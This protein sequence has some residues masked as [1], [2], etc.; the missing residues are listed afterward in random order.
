MRNR[1]SERGG[2]VLLLVLA[3][4][5]WAAAGAFGAHRLVL[6]GW[7]LEGD[8]LLGDRAALAADSALAWALAGAGP[9][10]AGGDEAPGGPSET[11]LAVPAWVLGPEPGLGL[12]GEVRI[13]RL[14]P[15]PA[16]GLW[17]R[18]TVE[19]RV[20]VPATRPVRTFRQI[21]EAYGCTPPGGTPAVRAW[22][23]VR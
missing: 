4:L 3:A 8:A 19:G 5:A 17:W 11:V 15:G 10:L 9:A 16:P 12:A 20:A 1:A 7:T 18:L 22:R 6:R 2:A 13:R 23:I 14:G 21:R